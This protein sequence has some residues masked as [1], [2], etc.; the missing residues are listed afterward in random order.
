VSVGSN[1]TDLTVLKS[2]ISSI[3]KGSY[4]EILLD[5]DFLP[6]SNV[7]YNLGSSNAR[8]K[9]LFLSGNTIDI[10]GVLVN[11]TTDGNLSFMNSN[12]SL[13]KVVVDEIQIGDDSSSNNY[14]SIRKNNMT[15]S[16]DVVTVASNGTKISEF[17]LNGN[18]DNTKSSLSVEECNT[19]NIDLNTS[20]SILGSV[21]PVW[22]AGINTTDFDIVPS[23][24]V[25]DSTDSVVV[26]GD[27]QG[28]PKIYNFNSSNLLSSLS[29]PTATTASYITKYNSNG[30]PQWATAITSTFNTTSVNTDRFNSIY[31]AG[32]YSNVL[33]SIYTVSSVGSNALASNITFQTRSNTTSAYAVKYSNSG[34]AQWAVSATGHGT[35]LGTSSVTDSHQNL[36][37]AGHY[38]G[39]A[40]IIYN[41]ENGIVNTNQVT[42]ILGTTNTMTGTGYLDTTTATAQ[43]AGMV[44]RGICFDSIGTYMYFC[45]GN[46][47]RVR[48]IHMPTGIVKT[49]AGS[50][51]PGLQDGVGAGASF[52]QPT[53]ICIDRTNTYL[54]VTET[55]NN[56]IRRITIETGYVQRIAGSAGG[57]PGYADGNGEHSLFNI[58][59]DICCT[60]DTLFV[61]DTN[62]HRIRSININDYTVST[63]AGAVP[64]YNDGIGNSAYFS[65]PYG[66]CVDP[67]MMTLYIT[68]TY[69]N[70]IRALNISTRAVTTI[71]GSIAGFADGTG[72]SAYFNNPDG[73][74]VDPSNTYIY[75]TDINNY[76]IRRI[77]IS[78]KSVITVAGKGINSL[79]D[80]PLE[81]S[82]FSLGAY[83]SC[84]VH[85]SGESVYIADTSNCRIRRIALVQGNNFHT[86]TFAGA[87]VGATFRD[88][89]VIP[90][91]Y[92]T[93]SD[94]VLD[95]HDN[96]YV[97]DTNNNVIRK[98][99]SQGFTITL[100]GSGE[101]GFADGIGTNAKFNKPSGICIDTSLNVLFVCDTS[102]H[103][104]RKIEIATGVVT[105]IAGSGTPS[106][107]DGIGIYASFNN[108]VGICIDFAFTTL[109]I[110]DMMNHRVRSI[111]I[112]TNDVTTLAGSG[113][114]SFLNGTANSASFNQPYGIS[115]NNT[116]TKLY[117]TDS[118]NNMI[119]QIII[120]SGVV[121][122]FAGTSAS[123]SA[124]GYNISATFNC[125]TGLKCDSQCN[126]LYVSDKSNN[127]IRRV[128]LYDTLVETVA[129]KTTPG[130]F[131]SVGTN[132]TFNQPRGLTLNGEGDKLFVADSG[133]NVIRVINIIKHDINTQSV[134]TYSGVGTAGMTNA[135]ISGRVTSPMT[136][137][138]NSTNT[139]VYFTSGHAIC[140][141]NVKTKAYNIIAGD[142]TTSG[143]TDGSGKNSRFNTPY[144]ICID[145]TNTT[146]YVADSYNYRVRK[147]TIGAGTVTT[148]AGSTSGHAD[149]TGSTASF[150]TPY[151]ICIDPTDTYL[152]LTDQ[153]RIKRISIDTRFVTTI[154]GS[155]AGLTDGSGTSALFSFI[156]GVC[157]DS[158][159]SNL[160]IVDTGNNRIRKLVLSTNIVSTIAGTG[161][162]GSTDGNGTVAT[163][164]AP[165]GVCIDNID[166]NIYI[167]DFF[168][169]RKLTLS[170]NTVSTIAGSSY[171][172]YA[173]GV[174]SLASFNRCI[175]IC[176]DITNSFIYLCDNVNNRI[177]QVQ[178]NTSMITTIAGDGSTG[179]IETPLPLFNSVY[180]ISVDNEKD[181][182]I[183][184]YFNNC[185]RKLDSK[186][187]VTTIC[188]SGFS[189]NINTN[190]TKL[191]H[192]GSFYHPSGITIDNF[193]TLY[194]IDSG[195]NCVRT[196]NNLGL[197]N[198]IVGKKRRTSVVSGIMDGIG[199]DAI[200]S[201]FC[202]G[203]CFDSTKSN[204]YI[205]DVTYIRKYN[206]LSGKLTTIVGSGSTKNVDGIGLNAS[207]YNVRCI[208]I[209][210]TDTFLY[211]TSNNSVRQ[212]NLI[213]K[214]VTT[215]AGINETL[216]Y[217]DGIGTN[218]RFDNPH[219]ICIDN[220]DNLYVADRNNNVIRKIAITTKEVTTF[221]GSSYGTLDGFGTNSQFKTPQAIC[222]NSTG[223]ILY[224]SELTCI[225]Q[226]IIS[227]VA[228]TTIAGNQNSGGYVDG[229]GESA[230]IMSPTGICTDDTELYFTDS[231][232]VRKATI[233]TG[234]VTTIAGVFK[235]YADNV[236]SSAPLS[237]PQQTCLDATSKNMYVAD[238]GT[239]S[240]KK[241]N[242]ATRHVS[243][244]AGSVL[245]ESGTVDGVGTWARFTSPVGICIDVDNNNLYVVENHRVRKVVISTGE[246]ITLAG[247]T[248]PGF[249]DA[250]ETMARFNTPS[251]ICI[252]PSNTFVYVA[253]VGN[254]RIRKVIIST[255]VVTTFAGTGTTGSTDGPGSTSSFNIPRSIAIDIAG[256][257][258]VADVG[259]N[260]IRRITSSGVVSTLAGN[261]LP[262]SIDSI[263]VA[264]AFNNPSC[265][266]V[267][268]L[269]RTAYI[270]QVDSCIRRISVTPLF[271]IDSK[272]LPTSLAESTVGFA[273]KYDSRGMAQYI[274]YIA[275]NNGSVTV[276]SVL[277]DE[278]DNWY[279]AG[280]YMGILTLAS[281]FYITG[282]ITITAPINIRAYYV[283]KYSAVGVPQWVFKID[284][285]IIGKLMIA[286]DKAGGLVVAGMY[287][288]PSPLFH[289]TSGVAVPN[290]TVKTSSSPSAFITRYKSNGTPVWCTS[291]EGLGNTGSIKSV[292]VDT[293]NNVYI[294]GLYTNTQAPFI[295]GSNGQ[296][297]SQVKLPTPLHGNGIGFVIKY[298]SAGNP[299]DALEVSSVGSVSL[300]DVKVA[301]SGRIVCV[302]NYKS[303]PIFKNNKNEVAL[304]VIAPATISNHGTLVVQYRPNVLS[305][306]NLLSTLTCERNGFQK[307]ITNSGPIATNI[308]VKVDDEESDNVSVVT[309][310]PNTTTV[311]SWY[312]NWYRMM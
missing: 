250:T 292:D 178:L 299:V 78:T 88:T 133:N 216:G 179:S 176:L 22:S 210:P 117:I 44:P 55:V 311:Y 241:I 296:N 212:V 132:A 46:N 289:N 95:A 183:S 154:A 252:D 56:T 118:L 175:G 224:V 217:I 285:D 280:T 239:N 256:S 185:I 236:F 196:I 100:A 223:T 146:L 12:N 23:S 90:A 43:L 297:V 158:S 89:I 229:V 51:S 71:A 147:I 263:G 40:P 8:W 230:L 114:A 101:T 143:F 161:S 85:P 25:V 156:Y 184:D 189:A 145:S 167:T 122:T 190:S 138:S 254:K 150:N 181:L 199:T 238:S 170:T 33:P 244:L 300:N 26:V 255:G 98:I 96:V 65:Y 277:T 137:C 205:L 27:Y 248:T 309:L 234:V 104:I 251:S 76:R 45:D 221:S 197:V 177:R 232:R 281:T 222:I 53:G 180:G 166:Q 273:I 48:R 284:G 203:S 20:W 74:S 66:V 172:Q 225:R 237:Y 228:V 226:I 268:N 278:K 80:G 279:I 21:N 240:I 262:I 39:D 291:V 10:A 301:L 54:Y 29:L 261:G 37:L 168:K 286:L 126:Y 49:V 57:A 11:R 207:L 288:G 36:Y 105:T 247:G 249:T 4:G 77:D 129:G 201:G 151:A 120:S 6:S 68:D 99:D 81:T 163:F 202:N 75:V 218:S 123:G 188:G 91:T 139:Y 215:I 274:A 134:A 9:N 191:T 18:T 124:N 165:N 152:Y 275:S 306:Y 209:D 164:N 125:P 38:S 94:C 70:R 136:I 42:T 140:Q 219:G 293:S 245:G 67:S 64:G 50:D 130:F 149:G 173:D 128:S 41:S 214:E 200:F 111:N 86:T 186:G 16:V 141:L 13:V 303:S 283:A 52:S 92:S 142:I 220:F 159:N 157:I 246:V 208:C 109:Y 61:A 14:V 31:V 282:A 187:I 3:T 290:I 308:I 127:M 271:S 108:P 72:N 1:L 211:L 162:A 257:L 5:A 243:V 58:P 113:T 93:P 112:S 266:T 144:G 260:S 60:D 231:H 235:G 30:V 19:S 242:L 73:I 195:N 59:H 171:A 269:G 110:C 107:S 121:S 131:N 298:S 15:N 35:T 312:N 310:N 32:S 233:S 115:G 97:A 69:N 103:A 87:G 193:G 253:D 160:Y 83:S 270:G 227:T 194:V 135:V 34:V 267:D 174:G 106:Y 169:V 28:M 17:A 295:Y 198:T 192:S 272:A 2:N 206:L 276:A 287:N 155:S 24:I 102:N 264:T 119:R 47:H 62:N 7:A 294:A 305:S 265:V 258:L 153:H 116:N 307:Y 82:T 259:N 304:N 213:T 84:F 79:V 302:G 148:I 204:M 63:I 182:Y